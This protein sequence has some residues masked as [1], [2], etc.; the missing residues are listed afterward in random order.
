MQSAGM[1]VF[2]ENSAKSTVRDFV[3]GMGWGGLSSCHGA[4]EQY[5]P[6]GITITEEFRCAS[7]EMHDRQKVIRAD[8]TTAP[9]SPTANK[10]QAP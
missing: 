2:H 7:V 6:P 1:A 9:I 3:C 5:M 10:G 4:E 8:E